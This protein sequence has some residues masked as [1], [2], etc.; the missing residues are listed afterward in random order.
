MILSTVE[1]YLPDCKTAFSL[2]FNKDLLC[3]PVKQTIANTIRQQAL[4]HIFSKLLSHFHHLSRNS[5]SLGTFFKKDSSTTF[6]T[7]ISQEPERISDFHQQAA[8]AWDESFPS[9]EQLIL[10]YFEP[11][12]NAGDN[13]IQKANCQ[14]HVCHLYPKTS[15]ENS[16]MSVLL[17]QAHHFCI[18]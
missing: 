16:V 1:S 15:A 6:R 7:S 4:L 3:D 5:N 10:S 11:F 13:F 17:P 14:W 8:T 18:C 2:L 9:T 12:Q